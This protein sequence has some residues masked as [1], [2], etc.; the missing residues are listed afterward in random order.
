MIPYMPYLWLALAVIF[1]LVE[2][3]TMGLTSVWFA[4]G[5]LAAMVL[6]LLHF[7]I[8]VQIGGF[9]AAALFLLVM[10]RPITRKHFVIGKEKTNA[11]RIIGMKAVVLETIDNRAAAGQIRVA[12]QV[13]TARSVDNAVIPAGCEVQVEAISGVKA[14]VRPVV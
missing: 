2:A 8:P 6:A 4:F 7:S 11:D 12:G 1:V 10:I 5:S 14:I 3:G 9:L 13:W